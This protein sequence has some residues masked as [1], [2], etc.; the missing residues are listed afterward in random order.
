MGTRF[1]FCV[2]RR[3]AA[4]CVKPEDANVCLPILPGAS[5]SGRR[6]GMYTTS[7]SLLERL[8]QP[9]AQE[10][11]ARFVDLYTP[12]LYTW[13]RR[14]GL[15]DQDAADLV[16]DVFV[17][18]VQKLPEFTYDR[19]KSFR[20]W[21]RTV[22]LNLLR[23]KR[24]RTVPSGE[25]AGVALSELVQPDHDVPFWEV[26][27]RQYLVGRA[28]EVM[29]AEFQPSTWKAFWEYVVCGRPAA[30]VAGELGLTVNAVYLARARVLSRLR[31]ELQGL[32]D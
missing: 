23:N 12:L 25:D 31:Q 17:L 22:T 32:L 29:Q 16:Q 20:A 26:E 9:A 21:L 2:R 14:L 7:V 4:E 11:W 19:H 5:P 30:P 27:Y 18:L 28:L 8:R 13:A 1:F 6:R 24:R 3:H 10:A 15:Q